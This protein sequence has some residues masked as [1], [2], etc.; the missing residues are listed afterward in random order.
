MHFEADKVV[1]EGLDFLIVLEE[2]SLFCLKFVRDL[3][4]DELG[5]CMA[6]DP[7]SAHLL[8]QL[9]SRDQCFILGLIIGS[10][11]I[12]PERMLNSYTAWAL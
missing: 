5:I 7:L 3:A 11:K 4:L 12:K 9:K 6:S 2:S 1:G 8:S 10:L